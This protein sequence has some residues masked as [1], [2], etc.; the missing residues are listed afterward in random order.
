MTVGHTLIGYVATALTLG[1]IRPYTTKGGSRTS[2]SAMVHSHPGLS[3]FVERKKRL[4]NGNSRV[5]ALSLVVV[6]RLFEKFA[7][8]KGNSHNEIVIVQLLSDNVALPFVEFNIVAKC[9]KNEILSALQSCYCNV[10]VFVAPMATYVE[11]WIVKISAN[12]TLENPN[13]IQVF[14][15]ISHNNSPNKEQGKGGACHIGRLPNTACHLG[16]N[17]NFLFGNPLS[18]FNQTIEDCQ[19]GI[20]LELVCH[21]DSRCHFIDTRLDHSRI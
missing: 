17:L 6:G 7:T 2:V 4:P 20:H 11:Q 8:N 5:A 9:V 10:I 1:G 16:S 15:E 12:R 14:E 21:F 3:T 19:T 18:H 13:G